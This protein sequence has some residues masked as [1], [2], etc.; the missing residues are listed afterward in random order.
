VN[1]FVEECRREWKR[2]GVPE[3]VA[4]E[5]AADLTADLREAEEEGGTPEDVLGSAAFDP[6]AFAA[7]WALE[8]GVTQTVQPP[9][10]QP[11][12]TPG[13]RHRSTAAIVAFALVAV[14]GAVLLAASF[15]AGSARI[16]VSAAGAP[17]VVLPGFEVLPPRV[18]PRWVPAPAGVAPQIEAVDVN[19]PD[20]GVRTAG[21][22]L[23]VVGLGGILGVVLVG[24]RRRPALGG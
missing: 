20:D 24:R 11:P 13:R 18:Q 3:P 16:A 12:S 8:R 22:L 10:T 14:T 19:G 1:E 2:L 23:L 6:R 9:S 15:A 7:A 4:N 17:R 5:M 21:A